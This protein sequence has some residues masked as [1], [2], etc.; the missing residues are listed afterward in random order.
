MQHMQSI[1]YL[2]TDVETDLLL[3]TQFVPV[4]INKPTGLQLNIILGRSF[5]GVLIERNGGGK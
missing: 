1:I 2:I 5:F 4:S 3:E